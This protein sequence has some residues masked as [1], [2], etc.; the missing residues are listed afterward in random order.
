M[1]DPYIEEINLFA[2]ALKM[3]KELETLVDSLSESSLCHLPEWTRMKGCL[4]EGKRSLNESEYKKAINCFQTV[5][6]TA[7]GFSTLC[8]RIQTCV[9]S[10]QKLEHDPIAC[11]K[12]FFEQIAKD[13]TS[14]LSRFHSCVT[15]G[16]VEQTTSVV[17]RAMERIRKGL[18]FL[19]LL[20]NDTAHMPKVL[21]GR[22][23]RIVSDFVLRPRET[24]S[25]PLNIKMLGDRSV[26]EGLVRLLDLENA[27]TATVQKSSFHDL[28]LSVDSSVET[29]LSCSSRD[30]ASDLISIEE[31]DLND[32]N[33]CLEQCNQFLDRRQAIIDLAQFLKSQAPLPNSESEVLTTFSMKTDDALLSNKHWDMKMLHSWKVETEKAYNSLLRCLL[34]T[35]TKRAEAVRGL[36][37]GF[38]NGALPE[39]AES[40]IRK[41]VGDILRGETLARKV[42]QD[43]PLEF[44]FVEDPCTTE[45]YSTVNL[46]RVVNYENGVRSEPLVPSVEKM[47]ARVKY[48]PEIACIIASE[49][50][51]N[52]DQ[53]TFRTWL[54]RGVKSGCSCCM[55]NFGVFLCQQGKFA[56]AKK[57]FEMAASQNNAI[58]RSNAKLIRVFPEAL[59]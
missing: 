56:E 30:E 19:H 26:K 22:V 51:K 32:A 41:R 36:Y 29:I 42:S 15:L 59:L 48:H 38:A 58:A 9:A 44:P 8:K 21:S 18:D 13:E 45:R 28:T 3:E 34:S 33:S 57:L 25:F 46:E 31:N 2:T 7:T 14:F 39:K 43:Y 23:E 11:E 50:R 35:L 37:Q 47:E 54:E 52:G 24:G 20:R 6:A 12:H 1:N 40:E 49:Y 55:N 5:K 10:F 53:D 4:D 16:E 27:F 17:E